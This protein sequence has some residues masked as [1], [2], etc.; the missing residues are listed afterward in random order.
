MTNRNI[1]LDSMIFEITFHNRSYRPHISDVNLY[2]EWKGGFTT[3]YDY[4]VKEPERTVGLDFVQRVR[5]I[6]G[7][8]PLSQI[9][10][11]IPYR[12][13]CD[14]VMYVSYDT[15]ITC[16]DAFKTHNKIHYIVDDDLISEENALYVDVCQRPWTTGE[17]NIKINH[18]PLDRPEPPFF[19]NVNCIYYPCWQVDPEKLFEWWANKGFPSHG[20]FHK[21]MFYDQLYAF[22]RLKFPG[23]DQFVGTLSRTHPTPEPVPYTQSLGDLRINTITRETRCIQWHMETLNDSF[24]PKYPCSTGFPIYSWPSGEELYNGYD[25]LWFKDVG[26]STS[27]G[28]NVVESNSLENVTSDEDEDDV[29]WKNEY[30][31]QWPG[32]Y[33]QDFDTYEDDTQFA[34]WQVYCCDWFITEYKWVADTPKMPHFLRMWLRDRKHIEDYCHTNGPD[35]IPNPYY[36]WDQC[37]QLYYEMDS[38]SL[39][40][41]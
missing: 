13:E 11:T 22:Y 15:A 29:T 14:V 7:D 3:T 4:A 27:F 41:P 17:E 21:P 40:I 1:P 5:N 19:N 30:G 16:G 10:C 37:Y 23:N 9:R 12:L 18:I 2:G 36:S 6:F 28:F 20:A 24:H 31:D 32:R 25:K 39:I 26:D 33:Y 34:G 8:I 35:S 38:T